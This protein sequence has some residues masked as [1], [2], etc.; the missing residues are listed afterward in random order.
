ML[1]YDCIIRINTIGGG[2][3]IILDSKS[4][5]P[6]YLQLKSKI[7]QLIGAGVLQKNQQLPPVRVLARD[8]GV[9]P[10]TVQR[11]YT[12]L[13]AQGVIYQIVGK[14]SFVSDDIGTSA[15][16]KSGKLRELKGEFL[17]AGQLGIVRSEIIETLEQVYREGGIRD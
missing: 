15:A 3:M 6:I 14:G 16:L 1:N 5:E 9:N 7:I 10:N 8:L 11:A 13:E 2:Y 12:E 17:K 4:K